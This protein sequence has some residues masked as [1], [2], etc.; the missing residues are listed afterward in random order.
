VPEGM[1][2]RP[3]IMEA[4]DLQVSWVYIMPYVRREIVILPGAQTHGQDLWRR[5][6]TLR[7]RNINAYLI[8]QPEK[9]TV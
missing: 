8:I 9:G 5:W 1:S 3:A 6:C 2:T 7:S 4:R